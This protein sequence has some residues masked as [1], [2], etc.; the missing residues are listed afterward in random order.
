MSRIITNAR[1]VTVRINLAYAG[2]YA[3][4]VN[5]I[6]LTGPTIDDVKAKAERLG[7][8]SID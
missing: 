7:W 5:G 8:Q 4:A 1:G 2:C 3:V 6:I